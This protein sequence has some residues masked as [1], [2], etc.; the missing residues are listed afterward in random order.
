MDGTR[1]Y[2]GDSVAGIETRPPFL[3]LTQ[4]VVGDKALGKTYRAKNFYS[5]RSL[6][7]VLPL[8][9][10]P[11]KIRQLAGSDPPGTGS[12]TVI[13]LGIC[14]YEFHGISCGVERSF[15]GIHPLAGRRNYLK[16]LLEAAVL[17]PR[18]VFFDRLGP[19]K[20]LMKLDV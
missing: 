17:K 18:R 5:A 6:S 12:T 1:R 13:S 4:S 14:S 11:S 15:D 8:L 19:T 3:Y 10:M 2:V 16:L 9:S 7:G 20:S